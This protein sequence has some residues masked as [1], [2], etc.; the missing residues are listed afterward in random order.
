MSLWV[1]AVDSYPDY[2]LKKK[3]KLSNKKRK[4]NAKKKN[5]KKVSSLKSQDVALCHSKKSNM[6][7]LLL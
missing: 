5:R 3:R 4:K 7:R 6:L 2:D 1:E